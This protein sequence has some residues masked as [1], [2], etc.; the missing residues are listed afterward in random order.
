MSKS[1]RKTNVLGVTCCKSEKKDKKIYNKTLR[2]KTK[3]I[4]KDSDDMENMQLPIK[5]DVSDPWLMG[6]DGK[7]RFDKNNKKW[8]RK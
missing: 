3:Q 7:Q 5:K 1:K 8:W 6:K 2:R 4:I